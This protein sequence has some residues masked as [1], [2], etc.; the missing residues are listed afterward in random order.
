VF[1]SRLFRSVFAF[2]LV[3]VLAI[4]CGDGE[5]DNNSSNN[6]VPGNQSTVNNSTSN[7][8]TTNNMSNNG[9]TNNMTTPDDCVGLVPSLE[10]DCDLFCQTGCGD[11]QACTIALPDEQAAAYV[12]SCVDTGAGMQG[13]DCSADTDC[14]EGY[15]CREPEMGGSPVCLQY[16]RYGT[17]GDPSCP[18]EL[19]CVPFL[20]E[21]RAGTCQTPR[22]DCDIFPTDT[23][24]DGEQCH[25]LS[26]TEATQ[27]LVDGEAE[28]DQPCETPNDC[29]EGLRCVNVG[30]SN[31][32]KILC[33]PNSEFPDAMCLDEDV[34]NTQADA[35]AANLTWGACY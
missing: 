15:M 7:N 4:G 27:C 10:G 2:A 30:G 11:E 19:E 8:V 20:R 17:E 25:E 23:C 9:T 35:N 1:G 5:G 14:A 24:A 32:C 18:E 16:C 3:G 12:S 29:I 31:V 33:D 22:S 26:A 28:R 6:I 21:I 34:C 13:D